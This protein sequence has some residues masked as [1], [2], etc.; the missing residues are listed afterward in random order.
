MP[1][2]GTVINCM[3]GRVQEQVNEYLK[4][5]FGVEFIDVITRPGPDG[6]LAAGSNKGDIQNLLKMVDVS[7]IKHGSVKIAVTAHHD[8]AGNPVSKEEHLAHLDK[9]ADFL[10]A[11]YPRCEII[12]L[13]IGENWEVE[14]LSKSLQA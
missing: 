3:D 10:S 9:S 11:K 6:L 12:K 8:C 7:V 4:N 13:W 5:R 1:T 14:E 2:F